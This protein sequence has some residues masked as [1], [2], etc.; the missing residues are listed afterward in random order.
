MGPNVR[1][2]RT[3]STGAALIEFAFVALTLIFLVFGA[4]EMDR[5]L[6]VY[7]TMANATRA[8]LRYAVVH[9]VDI[10]AGGIVTADVTQVV[11]NF[12]SAG[13][14]NAANVNVTVTLVDGNSQPGSRVTVKAVYPYDPFTTYFPLSVNLGSTA[15]GVIAF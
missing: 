1:N 14:L 11:R 8:G 4:I 7:P 6:L 15:E 2:R 3:S 10:N 5:M 13:I 9:G 12:A